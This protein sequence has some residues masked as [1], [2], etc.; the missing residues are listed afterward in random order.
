MKTSP[1]LAALA[2]LVLAGCG[3]P[4]NDSAAKSDPA[5]EA[6][7]AEIEAAF[8]NAENTVDAARKTADEPELVRES[9]GIIHV[10]AKHGFFSK[11]VSVFGENGT[12]T[13]TTKYSVILPDGTAWTAEIV[14]ENGIVT[15]AQMNGRD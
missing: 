5:L 10:D 1:L 7:A 11:S 2:A 12:S 8:A 3:E 13:E 9:N 14:R 6:K 4:K 15:K